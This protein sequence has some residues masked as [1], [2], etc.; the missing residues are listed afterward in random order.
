[1]RGFATTFV[2]SLLIFALVAAAQQNPTADDLLAQARA[3]YEQQGAKPALPQFEA[4]LKAFRDRN[5]R[6]GEAIV[7]GLIGNCYKHLGDSE[8]AMQLLQS[9]LAIK[10]ELSDALEEAKTLSNIGLLY[11]EEGKFPL[12]IESYQAALQLAAEISNPQLEGSIRNNLGLVLDE[13]GEYGKS[14]EQYQRALLL[15]RAAHFARGEADVLGN[16]GGV[17]LNLGHYGEALEHY[18]KSTAVA[19]SAGLQPSVMQNLGN[20][21]I[22]YT[23]QGRITDALATFDRAAAMAVAQGAKRE[24]AD[25]HKDKGSALLQIGRYDAALQE[26]R[27]GERI[28]KEGGEARQQS[29]LLNDLGGLYL[30]IGDL[31]SAEKQFASALQVALHIGYAQGIASAASSLGEVE[32]RRGQYEQARKHFAN[33]L[34]RARTTGDDASQALTLLQLASLDRE[35]SRLGEAEQNARLGLEAARRGGAP[36]LEARALGA[37]GEIALA[38]ANVTSALEHY[39]AAIALAQPLADSELKWQLAFGEG[40][41]FEA[42]HQY[43]EAVA[44][45][46]SAVMQ[47]ES[48]RDRLREERFRAGYLQGRYDVYI[49]LVR[50]LVKLHRLDD[51]F[52]YSE[53]LR[54]RSFLDLLNQQSAT[55]VS[56]EL[57]ELRARIRHLQA[58]IKVEESKSQRDQ[59]ASA[60]ILSDELAKAE[61]RYQELLDDLRSVLPESTVEGEM[62]VRSSAEVSSALPAD[63]ALLEYVVGRESITLFCLSSRGLHATSIP[64]SSATLTAKVGLLRDLISDA[65]RDDWRAPAASLYRQLIGP[66]AVGGWLRGMR[67]LYIVPHG[68]LHYLPFAVLLESS[69]ADARFLIQQYSVQNLPSAS[70]LLSTRKPSPTQGKMLAFAPAFARL[71]FASQEAESVARLFPGGSLALVGRQATKENFVRLAGEYEL[72]HLATHG[73]FN[74]Q[75]PMFSGVQLQPSGSDDGTLHVYEILSLRLRARLVTLSA[76]DTALGAGY[77]SDLPPGDEF[78]GLTRAFLSAGGNSVMATLWQVNDRSTVQF[79]LDFYRAAGTRNSELALAQAQRAMLKAGP[80]RH[81]YYWAAFVLNGLGQ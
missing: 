79:M 66:A 75:N 1:V 28:Y 31:S 45:Y 32:H 3:T 49:A 73:Y 68:I 42:A 46:R 70:L 15:D 61:A 58:V 16:I 48:V 24:E 52:S 13:Q 33:A 12:A 35:Q 39:R 34:Q 57:V 54:A 65:D 25:W 80:Y 14:M 55:G 64:V 69:G 76:C 40:R 51:A 7:L 56:E 29:E 77:F 26:Y 41:A 27:Q 38:Q 23:A 72:L 50:L 22:I 17:Y 30:S 10:H 11:W 53:K 60:E 71:R 67:R 2:A 18:Q 4:A 19:E 20:I 37:Q 47:I 63:A 5:D 78:V 9:A 36:L 74:R 81:P 21:G 8:R 44:A 62:R 43:E 59:R 6:H